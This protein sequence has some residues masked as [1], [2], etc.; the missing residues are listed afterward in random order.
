MIICMKNSSHL[1]GR[2]DWSI[3]NQGKVDSGIRNQIGLELI[4]INVESSV[5]SERGCDGGNNLGDQTVQV[6]VGR[7]FNV[8]VS[9]AD[10]VDGLVVDHEGTVGVLQGGVGA[11][12]GVVGLHHG[13]GHLG[14]GVNGE[15]ELR[16][17][18]IVHRQTLHQ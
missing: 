3:S 16:L 15:L 1:L 7:T 18:A 14:G 12:C 9:S 13:R 5:K 2:N 8:E 10:V 6:G 4:Q 17:L 11:Q